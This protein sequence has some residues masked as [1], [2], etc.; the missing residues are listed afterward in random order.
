MVGEWEVGLYLRDD[1]HH[2]EAFIG[3]EGGSICWVDDITE[4]QA[5][6]LVDAHNRVLAENAR[7]REAL[8]QQERAQ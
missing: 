4:G 3:V 8:A 1:D 2:K 5:K 6:A 7:L